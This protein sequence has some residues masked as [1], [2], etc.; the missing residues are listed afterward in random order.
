MFGLLAANA[1]STTGSMMTLVAIPWFVLQTTGSAAKTGIATAVAAL[2]VILGSALGGAL[3]DRL[4]FKTASVLADLGSA[5][6]VIL[7]PLM[8]HTTG[9]A[10]WQLL[11]FVFLRGL[12]DSPG[13]TARTSMLPDLADRAGLPRSQV[14][15]ASQGIQRGAALLGPAIAG[16][17]IAFIGASHVLWVD[18]GS[19]AVSAL[20]VTVAIP[21]LLVGRADV[22]RSAG[23]LSEILDGLRFVRRNG[24][25]LAI[26]LTAAASNFCDGLLTVAAP[27]YA[28]DVLGRP[29]DLGMMF[30]GLG[31]GGLTG[32]LLFGRYG[33]HASRRLLFGAG[34]IGVGLAFGTLLL[35]PGRIGVVAA[36]FLG[37]VAAGPINPI[38]LTVFQDHTL[39]E[40]RGRIFGLLTAVAWSMIPVGRLLGGYLVEW[41]GLRVALAVIAAGYLLAGFT[42][43]VAPIFSRMDR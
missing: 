25:L 40:M 31:A 8:Y 21:G 27:V 12:F 37:G 11:L 28:Q 14:N 34:F 6:S 30:S 19:F 3:V 32:I 15:A 26:A 33:T 2:P 36:M 35:L 5:A 24:L 16:V 17:L 39:P 43:S 41:T 20:I 4:G 13:N 42:A 22:S 38:L 29:I 23:Y 10:F 1:I 7:I 18:A 9:L